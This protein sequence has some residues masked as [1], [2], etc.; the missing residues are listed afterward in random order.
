MLNLAPL[1]PDDMQRILERHL[2]VG[3]GSVEERDRSHIGGLEVQKR[4]RIMQ[5]PEELPHRRLVNDVGQ[6]ELDS[7]IGR[8]PG[9]HVTEQIFFQFILLLDVGVGK[10]VLE[11]ALVLQVLF[12][13][14][15][16]ELAVVAEVEGRETV[17]EDGGAGGVMTRRPFSPV[18]KMR[19]PMLAIMPM[20][21]V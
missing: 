21:V 3:P 8:Q 17:G 1:L 13:A 20:P 19:S 2:L 18:M 11:D 4:E 5:R 16:D 12:L 6:P 7:I 10:V 9:V 14:A 15:G